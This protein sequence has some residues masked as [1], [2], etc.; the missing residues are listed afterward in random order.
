MTGT[1]QANFLEELTTWDMT[2]TMI[3]LVPQN[4]KIRV[5][6]PTSF[7]LQDS[8]IQGRKNIDPILPTSTL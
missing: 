7:T 5:I 2:L 3:N 4:G 6:F 1:P 8:I